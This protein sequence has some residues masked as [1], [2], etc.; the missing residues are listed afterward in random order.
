MPVDSWSQDMQRH[1]VG[2]VV[3][4]SLYETDIRKGHGAGKFHHAFLNGLVY[5]YRI[6]NSAIR[7]Y[8]LARKQ[9]DIAYGEGYW[10]D[11]Y[12]ELIFKIGYELQ[13][14]HGLLIKP[15]AAFDLVYRPSKFTEEWAGGFVPAGGDAELKTKR[16][17]M[18]TVLGGRFCFLKRFYFSIETSLDMLYSR[19][20]GVERQ[21]FLDVENIDETQVSEADKEILYNPLNM[22]SISYTF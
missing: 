20:S 4:T 5:K 9:S 13:L 18:S 10:K 15:Y 8:A 2:P 17:G 6:N 3:F 11:G 16:Y 1:E 19:T 12:E 7:V 14:I 22:L 21:Y